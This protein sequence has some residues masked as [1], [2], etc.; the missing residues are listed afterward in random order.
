[1]EAAPVYEFRP[2]PGSFRLGTLHRYADGQWDVDDGKTHDLAFVV[3]EP[4]PIVFYFEPRHRENILWSW[5]TTNWYGFQGKH[6][7]GNPWHYNLRE[8]NTRWGDILNIQN[9]HNMRAGRAGMEHACKLRRCANGRGIQWQ[10]HDATILA[11]LVRN[12]E[13]KEILKPPLSPDCMYCGQDWVTDE[14]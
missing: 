10:L 7:R 9:H 1:M 13:T 4:G 3:N 5:L 6:P 12:R 8:G 11:G 2:L 14:R